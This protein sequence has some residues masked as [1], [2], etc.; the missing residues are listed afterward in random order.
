MQD[1]NTKP[2]YADMTKMPIPPKPLLETPKNVIFSPN[3]PS[4]QYLDLAFTLTY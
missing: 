4:M 3:I 2:F 1:C